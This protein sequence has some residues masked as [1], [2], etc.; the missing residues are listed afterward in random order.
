MSL[1]EKRRRFVEEYLKDLNGTQAAIR[2]GYA[3]GSAKVEGSRLLADANVRQAI[4]DASRIR[5][6]RVA[7]RHDVTVDRVVLELAKIGFSDIRK[8]VEWSGAELADEK[9]GHDGEG[10]DPV[11][12]IRAAN[13]V[14]LVGSDVVDDAT[15]AA[16]SEISQTKD[17]ALKVKMHNKQAALVNLLRHLTAPLQPPAEDDDAQGPRPKPHTDSWDG[18][19]Q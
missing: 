19:L 3:P 8:V 5:A 7:D 6:Q 17:G 4:Q 15:P 18:L 11:V 13:F 16:I 12:V 10:G 1:T 14:K 9:D 2:A